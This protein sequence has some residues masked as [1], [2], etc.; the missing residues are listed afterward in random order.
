MIHYQVRVNFRETTSMTWYNKACEKTKKTPIPAGW[1]RVAILVH[2]I[3]V[4]F[5]QSQ[6]GDNVFVTRTCCLRSLFFQE[7]TS[8]TINKVKHQSKSKGHIFS[9]IQKKKERITEKYSK[10]LVGDIMEYFLRDNDG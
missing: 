5:G 1:H 8:T 9:W 10:A 6:G 7:T 4:C 3:H 2:R